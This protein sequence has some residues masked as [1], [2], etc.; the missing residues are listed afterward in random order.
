MSSSAPKAPRRLYTRPGDMID[1]APAG[2]E[3]PRYNIFEAKPRPPMPS[4][5]FRFWD[6]MIKRARQNLMNLEEPTRRARGDFPTPE[7]SFVPPVRLG[8]QDPWPK[9]EAPEAQHLRLLASLVSSR[10]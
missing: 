10:A 3:N 2:Y 7:P 8:P 4:V 6:L 9:P 5:D 1:I